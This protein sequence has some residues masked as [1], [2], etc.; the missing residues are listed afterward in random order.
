M[1][2]FSI[3]AAGIGVIAAVSMAVLVPT[4]AGAAQ[5]TT[6]TTKAPT[7]IEAICGKVPG[8]VQDVGLS[9][10]LANSALDTARQNVTDKR[11][12]MTVAMGEMATAVVNH[13]TAL[14]AGANPTATGNVLKAKQATYVE[15]VVAWSKARTQVFDGEQLLIFGELHKTLLDSVNADACP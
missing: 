8:L 14:D 3:V 9:L 12:A 2:R 6:T 15:S 7:L 13:L 1:R 5:T 10:T 11:A 4:G